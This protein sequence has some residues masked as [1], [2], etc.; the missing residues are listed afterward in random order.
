MKR[1]LYLLTLLFV[2]ALLVSAWFA[3]PVAN[4]AGV[5]P[6]ATPTP[7]PVPAA[8][9]VI[10]P[11]PKPTETPDEIIKIDTELVNLNVRVVDR[12]NRPINNLQQ[13]EFKIFEDGVDQQ[14]DFF[15]KSDVP[16]NYGM[17]IDNSGSMRQLLDKVIEAGKILVDTNR[18]ADETMIIRFVSKDKIEIQQQFTSNKADL[19]DALENMYIEGGQTAIIDAVYLAVEN[20]DEYEKSQKPEDRKRR[21]LILVSDGE[22]R[23]SFYTEK[24]LFELLRESEVQIYVIGFVSEL[25]KEGGFVSKSPQD[26]AKAFLERIAAQTGGKTYFPTSGAELPNLAREIS[27]E[28]RTQYS[29]G[30]IPSNDKRDGTYRNIKVVV[31][32]GPKQEKRIAITRAGRVADGGATPQKLPTKN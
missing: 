21:A 32:D 16:T 17:V 11:T 3:K 9:S 27:N 7:A 20:I 18:P 23:N 14:I 1:S 6:T 26:K 31:N 22:D 8:T 29:I 25:S 15:S 2:G 5:D 10:A 24:Q 12:N 30:Y 4:A 28:L 19:N 13:N